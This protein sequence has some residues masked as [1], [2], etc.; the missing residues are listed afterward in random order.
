MLKELR[1]VLDNI[2][3]PQIR[4]YKKF[5]TSFPQ[6]FTDFGVEGVQCT[7]V[8]RVAIFTYKQTTSF[9]FTVWVRVFKR[10][11]EAKKV[12]TSKVKKCAQ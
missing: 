4:S 11:S 10:Y 3:I 5:P 7:S 8:S 12:M 9:H 1:K 2:Y 6:T